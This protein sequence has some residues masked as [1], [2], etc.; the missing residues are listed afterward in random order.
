MKNE[1]ACSRGVFVRA[2]KFNEKP[3]IPAELSYGA[4]FGSVS[5]VRLDGK[6]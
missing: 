1:W 2:L 3:L 6:E 5:W 4:F